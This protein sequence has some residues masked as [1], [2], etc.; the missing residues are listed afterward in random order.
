VA[1]QPFAP[2]RAVVVAAVESGPDVV[3]PPL[4]GQLSDVHDV[5]VAGPGAAQEPVDPQVT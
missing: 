5:T 3:T 2:C 4:E 1:G